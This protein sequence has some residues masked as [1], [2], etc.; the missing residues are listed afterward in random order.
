MTPLY[1]A[2]APEA[3]NAA[4]AVRPIT[5]PLSRERFIIAVFTAVTPLS[6]I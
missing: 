5:S 2:A 6:N 3:A 4:I 1:S